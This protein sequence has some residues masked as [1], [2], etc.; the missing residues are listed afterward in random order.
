MP[1][2][3][4]KIINETIQNFLETLERFPILAMVVLDYATVPQFCLHYLE[5]V[6][7]ERIFLAE[8]LPVRTFE[9]L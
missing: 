7:V 3:H 1:L 8:E 9:S 4:T 2:S 5:S 6:I